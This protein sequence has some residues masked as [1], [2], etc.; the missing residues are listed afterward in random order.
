MTDFQRERPPFRL[1]E[2][3]RGDDLPAIAAR[4]LGDANRWPELVWL[5]EL[6]PPFITDIEDLGI[7]GV[8]TTGDLIR[9]PSPVGLETDE[10]DVGGVFE[11]DCQL[12]NR[13]LQA[14]GNGDLA[15]VSGSKNLVQQL[16]HRINTPRGQLRRHPG[17]GCLVWGLLGKV[18]GPTA[19]ALGARHVQAALKADYR[20]ANVISSTAEISGAA[21][22]M[23]AKLETICGAGVNLPDPDEYENDQNVEMADLADRYWYFVNYE[24]PGDIALP[25]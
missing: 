21:V 11:R 7:P 15:V 14:D 17:Y 9:V 20:V 12:V 5:N 22:L 8:L 4:E 19:A 2:T 1:V 16:R 24:L 13:L 23:S 18:G 6:V 10:E 3:F 25:E